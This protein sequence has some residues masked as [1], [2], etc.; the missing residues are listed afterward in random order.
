MPV[1]RNAFKAIAVAAAAGLAWAAIVGELASGGE[2]RRLVVYSA[3]W[4]APCQKLKRD[5]ER[6]AEILR[7]ID[8]EYRDASELGAINVRVPD[9]RLMEGDEVVG[10]KVGYTDLKSFAEW[11]HANLL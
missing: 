3:E 9:I 1:L 5:L 8:V 4:C 7:G 11:L 10:R 2:Q 6:N